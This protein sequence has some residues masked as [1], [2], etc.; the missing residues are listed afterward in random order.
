M[1]KPPETVPGI[2]VPGI[3]MELGNPNEKGSKTPPRR[4][5]KNGSTVEKNGSREMR[6]I[7][8]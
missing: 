6:D 1:L 4:E 7:S 5:G 3:M 8:G 2:T